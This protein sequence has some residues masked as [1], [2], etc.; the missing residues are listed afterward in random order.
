MSKSTKSDTMNEIA[1]KHLIDVLGYSN[2]MQVG[3]IADVM[4]NVRKLTDKEFTNFG[5]FRGDIVD[6]ISLIHTLKSQSKT[7]KDSDY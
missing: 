3:Y 4:A 6:Y 5:T 1:K 2:D 7:L